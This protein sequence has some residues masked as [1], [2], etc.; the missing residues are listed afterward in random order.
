MSTR[1]WVV[2]SVAAV[3]VGILVLW[4]ASYPDTYTPP[5]AGYE[6]S[7]NDR[8]ITVGFCGSTSDTIEGSTF[9][10]DDRSVFVGV[11]LRAHRDQFANGTAH[12]VTFVLRAPIADRVVRDPSGNPVAR[13]SYVCPG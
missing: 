11:R 7:D 1:R 4:L 13:G 8:E 3:I 9:G 12:K 6:M 10:E 2:V 5:P